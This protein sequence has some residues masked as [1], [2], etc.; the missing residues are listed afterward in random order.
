MSLFNPDQEKKDP[1]D[2]RHCS[3]SILRRFRES[4]PLFHGVHIA[5]TVELKEPTKEMRIGTATDTLLFEPEAA[6]EKLICRDFGRT[7]AELAERAE[8]RTLCQLERKTLLNQ[9]ELDTA[10]RMADA[11]RREPRLRDLLSAK[12]QAQRKA[13]WGCPFTDY[14]MIGYIDADIPEAET[15]VELKT[16]SAWD[17][18]P[19]RLPRYAC[20]QLVHCQVGLYQMGIEISDNQRRKIELVYIAREPP[21][22]VVCL[23]MAG[24]ELALG[25][26][27]NEATLRE[28]KDCDDFG[29]WVSRWKNRPPA[30]HYPKWAFGSFSHDED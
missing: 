24:D 16:C 1:R 9:E 8:L 26:K 17:I 7:K 30:L 25:H 12:Y 4:I 20:N 15:I 29:S 13:L 22:E 18:Q 2:L 23:T 6:D 27:D 10:Q 5:K 28:L 21:Y 19:T 3:H 14:P 11:G